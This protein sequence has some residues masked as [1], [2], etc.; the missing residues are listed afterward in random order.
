MSGLWEAGP[1]NLDRLHFG[2]HYAF[3][4]LN[5]VISDQD[6][7]ELSATKGFPYDV[8]CFEDGMGPYSTIK[9]GPIGSK[10]FVA[11]LKMK[12][13]PDLFWHHFLDSRVKWYVN[14]KKCLPQQTY[15]N[16]LDVFY[17]NL[18]NIEIY[19][20]P[21]GK[22]KVSTNLALISCAM[23]PTMR[24]FRTRLRSSSCWIACCAALTKLSVALFTAFPAA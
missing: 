14:P 7:L 10:M 9:V 19:F 6:K 15:F 12:Y 4:E 1:R 24:L 8:W 5:F 11:I 21:Y 3:Y 23:P 16:G 13:T 17:I 18:F 22:L 2:R 20:R